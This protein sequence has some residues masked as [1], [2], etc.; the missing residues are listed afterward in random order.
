[1][2]KCIFVISLLLALQ[3]QPQT[4]TGI[5]PLPPEKVQPD[6]AREILN[7]I[8]WANPYYLWRNK[9]TILIFLGDDIGVL[10]GIEEYHLD[11]GKHNAL[12]AVNRRWLANPLSLPNKNFPDI[13][14]SAVLWP[15]ISPDGKWI[16]WIAYLANVGGLPGHLMTISLD[17]KHWTERLTNA[18]MPDNVGSV[19]WSHNSRSWIGL[20][21]NV[22]E[23][24]KP[25]GIIYDVY[26]QEVRRFDFSF[27]VTLPR[28]QY[29]SWDV[30][31][32]LPNGHLLLMLRQPGYHP[33]DDVLFADIPLKRKK[34][35][36][37]KGEREKGASKQWAI[38]MPSNSYASEVALSP[39]GDRLLWNLNFV[40]PDYDPEK[41]M[42]EAQ[43][44]QEHSEIWHSK[45]DGSDMQRL[46]D[47]VFDTSQRSPDDRDF[48][49]GPR[50]V[51]LQW[52]PDGTR[53]S[54]IY[55]R[56]LYLAAVP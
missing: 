55:D 8:G 32:Q 21:V 5:T 41:L 22:A 6:H 12:N 26:T 9:N 40:A 1:M 49:D 35:K 16:V 48:F 19:A 10:D 31:A 30:F 42:S 36:R 50:L 44:K 34:E 25:A 27:G 37:E 23:Y 54:Y 14:G 56:M 13:Q 17:G 33:N 24:D 3:G 46:G 53:I 11:T 29:A 4:R 45:L 20:F 2:H 39:S 15:T 43:R 18:G 38:H 28:G 52:S 7:C 51:G 47:M